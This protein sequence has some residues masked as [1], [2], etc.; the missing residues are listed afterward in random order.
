[1]AGAETLT[2]KG[3]KY[4]ESANAGLP[5]VLRILQL[6]YVPVAFIEP[7]SQPSAYQPT[8]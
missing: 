8:A 7:S 3:A 5:C 1:M 4:T 6:P 2:A